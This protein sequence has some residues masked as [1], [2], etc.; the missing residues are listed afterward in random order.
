MNRERAVCPISGQTRLEEFWNTLTH[1]VGTA[2]SIAGLVV[3]VVYASLNG[4]S[5]HIVSGTI[6]GTTLVLLYS[7][8]SLYH[9]ARSLRWKQIFLIC[10]YC[11]IY[12]VIA[13][14]YTPLALV[15]LHGEWGW[16]ILGIEWSMAIIGMFV[17]GMLGDRYRLLSTLAYLVMGWMVL[18]AFYPLYEVMDASGIA[19][20]IAG[21]VAYT[22]GVLF[23]LWESLPLNHVVWH[24]FV[25]LGSALHYFAILKYVM[26]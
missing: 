7:A 17:K 19:L 22:I 11:A 23:F 13:G 24:V 3:I 8:S 9:G 4:N 20:I 14:T 2:L 12:L 6:Y 21:G 18:V 15:T 1:G 25:I 26:P 10:D 5:L 16:W